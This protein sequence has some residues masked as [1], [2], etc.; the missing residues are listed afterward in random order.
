MIRILFICHSNICRSPMAE[1][2]MKDLVQKE[3]LSDQFYIASAATTTEGR[4]EPVYPPARRTLAEHGL[5]CK[6]KTARVMNRKEYGEWDLL[7]GMDS[8]NLR[9][10]R[11][12]FG[13]D[14][15]G[16][17]HLL[18]DYTDHPRDVADPWYT[19]DFEAT[20][21]DVTEGCCGLLKALKAE[22][23]V[24]KKE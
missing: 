16:K 12:I 3:G 11:Y 22:G 4:G 19:D 13:G 5:S 23:K 2:V 8:A 24:G 21:R 15:D 9:G 20:W 7:I 18:M 1:C 6:G 14:P 17:F 10:M